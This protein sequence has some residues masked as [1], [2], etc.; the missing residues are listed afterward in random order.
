VVL[1]NLQIPSTQFIYVHK[2]I[3]PKGPGASDFVVWG[4]YESI[5]CIWDT[6][7]KENDLD[8]QRISNWALQTTK[9]LLVGNFQDLK[10]TAQVELQ[11]S[12]IFYIKS[13]RPWKVKCG[14]KK[15]SW[16][17]PYRKRGHCELG[18]WKGFCSIIENNPATPQF[19]YLGMSLINSI[20]T[21]SAMFR[22]LTLNNQSNCAN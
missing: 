1:H 19:K 6:G 13:Q 9:N 4:F 22:M 15:Y 12:K 16:N 2:R 11:K 17:C 10:C 20:Y 8:L 3:Y 18:T 14:Y 21:A 7:S 5:L